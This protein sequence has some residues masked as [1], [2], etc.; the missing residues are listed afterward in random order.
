M[1]S[2]KSIQI[3]FLPFSNRMKIIFDKLKCTN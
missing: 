3:D 1:E 2:D